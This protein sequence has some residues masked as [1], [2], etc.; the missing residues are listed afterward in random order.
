MYYVHKINYFGPRYLVLVLY[1][2]L[3]DGKSEIKKYNNISIL[4]YKKY[5]INKSQPRLL[6]FK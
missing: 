3:E 1:R 5:I 6:F 2:P 4:S